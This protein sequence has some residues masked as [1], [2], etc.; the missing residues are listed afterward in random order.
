LLS[1]LVLIWRLW[2]EMKHGQKF[3]EDAERTA[4]KIGGAL[5]FALSIY[6][7]GFAKV[8]TGAGS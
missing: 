7:V 4:S 2:V 8:G 6:L 1:A 5:L 3:S